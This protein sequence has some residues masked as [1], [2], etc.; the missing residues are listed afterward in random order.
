MNLWERLENLIYPKS[1]TLPNLQA[2]RFFLPESQP[3]QME[4]FSLQEIGFPTLMV[5]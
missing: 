2:C 3:A 4:G 1:P 5:S